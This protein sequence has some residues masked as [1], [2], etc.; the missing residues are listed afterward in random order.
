METLFKSVACRPILVKQN[1]AQAS[2]I[3]MHGNAQGRTFLLTPF[4]LLWDTK[5]MFFPI[6]MTSTLSFI[7]ESQHIL[8]P[9]ASGTGSTP[10][11]L[12]L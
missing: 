5:P 1:V 9:W 7:I 3:K 8:S 12:A 10:I 4:H 6:T 2:S 11:S